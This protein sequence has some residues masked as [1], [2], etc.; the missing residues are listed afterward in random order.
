MGGEGRRSRGERESRVLRL[1]GEVVFVVRQKKVVPGLTKG[2]HIS[3]RDVV[4]T[5]G[6]GG[7]GLEL[8]RLKRGAQ[9]QLLVVDGHQRWRQRRWWRPQ[10]SP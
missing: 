9:G 7:V 8:R 6:G 1:G 10:G 4:A 3:R 5:S 2:G